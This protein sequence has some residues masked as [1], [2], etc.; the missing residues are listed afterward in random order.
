MADRVWITGAGGLIGSA[1]AQAVPGGSGRWEVCALRREDLDLLDAR[2]VEERFAREEPSMILHAAALS[3]SADCEADP[4]LARRLNVEVTSR[5]VRL[6]GGR[7]FVLFSTD[8]VFDGRKGG[9]V[10]GDEVGPLG[11]YASSKVAAEEAVRGQPGVMIVR[12]SLNGGTSPTGDRGFNEALRRAWG[13]GRET[14]LFEDEFRSPIHAAETARVVWALVEAG[15]EG[16]V[17][18]A[19]AERMSRW[20]LGELVAA[21]WPGLSPR[22]VRGRLAD[23]RGPRRAPDTTLDCSQVARLLG[24]V[25]MGLRLWL[26]RNPGVTF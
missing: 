1:L 15:V 5:L 2:L 18:V 26:E 16:V 23:Y 8:L 11:V 19:G 6:A 4:A 13:A 21:R 9:Y 7:P 24:G 25:P 22:L 12:T 14:C 20:E 3:R 17:H 10:E